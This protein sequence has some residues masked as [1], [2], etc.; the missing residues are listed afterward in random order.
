VAH[1]LQWVAAADDDIDV[2]GAA[3]HGL[4]KIARR[5]DEQ[6]AAAARA[7]VALTAEPLRREA[8]VM[9]L[10]ELPARRITEVAHGLRDS[11]PEVRCASVEAL[12]RMQ[13]AEAS[14]ALES[15]LDDAHVAVRLAAIRAL[16]NLGTRE[17]QRKLVTLART[18]PEAEVRRAAMFAAS[19][20]NG[21]SDSSRRS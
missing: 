12:G 1:L 3:V 15:A 16:K 13:L 21:D 10:S 8:A 17:P 19:R 4:A 9:A 6:G 18:D 11:S 2:V 5:G 20:S 7:L 14:R